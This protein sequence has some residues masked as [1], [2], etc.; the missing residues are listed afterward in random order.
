VVADRKGGMFMNQ[1]KRPRIWDDR[2]KNVPDHAASPENSRDS[3]DWYRD[4]TT[5]D[6]CLDKSGFARFLGYA[7]RTISRL[8]AEGLLPPADITIGRSRR[9]LMSTIERWL[10]SR[11]KLP[12]RRGRNG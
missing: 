1:H 11:P 7:V 3:A 2:G 9:W 12:A 4:G 5:L 6:R 10:K 8:D